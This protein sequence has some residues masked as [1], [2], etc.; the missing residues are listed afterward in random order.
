MRNGSDFSTHN[1]L[2]KR[3]MPI[4]PLS[5]RLV[6]VRNRVMAFGVNGKS[7]KKSLLPIRSASLSVA[8]FFRS[9]VFP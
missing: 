1:K 4:K 5:K 7:T 9:S 6:M 8:S 3:I 2:S